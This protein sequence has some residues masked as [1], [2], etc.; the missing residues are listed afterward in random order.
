MPGSEDVRF[1]PAAIEDDISSINSHGGSGGALQRAA[2]STV[3][4]AVAV[5]TNYF[6]ESLAMSGL[7]LG[8][9]LPH[10]AMGQ[11]DAEDAAERYGEDGVV[12]RQCAAPG[13]VRAEA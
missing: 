1:C 4:K 12:S 2:L 8:L 5:F 3:A 10:S 7:R 13:G 9:P 11:I 6:G